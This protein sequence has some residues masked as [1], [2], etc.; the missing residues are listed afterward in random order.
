MSDLFK[1]NKEYKEWIVQV[2]S[3]FKSSQIKT[4]SKVNEEML[5]FIGH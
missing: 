4:A 5:S 1:V 2:S 3:R